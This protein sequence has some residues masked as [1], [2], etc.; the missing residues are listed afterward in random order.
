MINVL[1]TNS[2]TI[3]VDFTCHSARTRFWLGLLQVYHVAKAKISV[4]IPYS[5]VEKEVFTTT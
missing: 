3:S 5:A 1:L 4:I 2:T